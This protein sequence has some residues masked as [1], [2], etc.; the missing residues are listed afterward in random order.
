MYGLRSKLLDCRCPVEWS[1]P[2]NRGLVAEWAA[3]PLPGWVG[4]NKFRDLVRGGKNPH[5]G[6]ITNA[7]FPPS[8]TSG[9]QGN[10]RGRRGGFG[11]VALDGTNDFVNCGN[12]GSIEFGTGDF[13]V[14][15]WVRP[16]NSAVVS[17]VGKRAAAAAT[18]QGWGIGA[19]NTTNAQVQLGDGTHGVDDT[20]V[21]PGSLWDGA[22][23]R[24]VV[25]YTRTATAKWYTDGILKYTTASIAAVTGSVSNTGQNLCLG[26]YNGGSQNFLLGLVDCVALYSRALTA[27]DVA[28]DYDQQRRGNPDR[29][30]WLLRKAYFHPAAA[31]TGLLLRRRRFIY[32]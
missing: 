29:W 4:A 11:C 12:G 31:A 30:R 32:Q 17:F 20:A 26:A 21:T 6:T 7:A 22:W 19:R 25:S 24:V 16:N 18:D 28:A 14:C 27:S 15:L 8:S 2:T 23:H 10:Q 5:D 3:V 13:S 1:H 9:W